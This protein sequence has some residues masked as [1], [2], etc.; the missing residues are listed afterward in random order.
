MFQ[1]T[2]GMLLNVYNAALSLSENF[3]GCFFAEINM[4]WME[5]RAVGACGMETKITFFF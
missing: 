5:E 3:K 2:C 1:P 4:D